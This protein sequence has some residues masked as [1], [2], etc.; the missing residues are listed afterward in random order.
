MPI[1]KRGNV[2]WTQFTVHG[3]RYQKSLETS[4]KRKASDEERKLI[5]QAEKGFLSANVTDTAR[6]TFGAALEIYLADRET[7]VSPKTKKTLAE[8]TKTT[9]AE[10]AVILKAHLGT[11]PVKKFTAELLHSYIR[12]RLK[13]VSH[14]TINRELN[15]VRGVLRQANLWAHL[16]D[17][18]KALPPGEEIGRA[19]S[20]EEKTQIAQTASLKPEWRNARLAYVLAVNTSMRPCEMKSLRW[21][22]LDW[23]QRMVTIGQSKTDAGKRTIPLNEEA[24]AAMKELQT[25]AKELFGDFLRADWFVFAAKSATRPITA[26]RTAWRSMLKTAKVPHTRF[27]NTRHTAITDLLQ[28]PAASEQ[29][30]KAIAGHVSQKMLERYS[31]TRTD[32]KRKAVESLS[33][34]KTAT[35]LLQSAPATASSDR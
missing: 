10:R 31:H 14:G 23:T 25:D 30:V 12:E 9:E 26:W 5:A 34:P 20:E 32:A 35:N 2:W 13:K 6:L 4:K 16:A 29:T 22:D 7:S 27:Y 15:L 33:Q 18:V 19:F 1:Y 3:Q 21:G 17:R 8:N 28:N 11:F 24:F